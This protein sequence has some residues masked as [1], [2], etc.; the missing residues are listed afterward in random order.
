[1]RKLQAVWKLRTDGKTISD[2][3]REFHESGAYERL[4]QWCHEQ[5]MQQEQELLKFL[6]DAMTQQDATSV[7]AQ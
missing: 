5:E 6:E 7:A 1:M 2:D 3:L 4:V